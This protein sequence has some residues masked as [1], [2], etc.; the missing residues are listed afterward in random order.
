MGKAVHAKLSSVEW[1]HYLEQPDEHAMD[2]CQES[3]CDDNQR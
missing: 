3:G 2:L 1:T